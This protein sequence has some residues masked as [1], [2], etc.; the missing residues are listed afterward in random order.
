M[1]ALKIS[2]ISFLNTV[3]LMWDFEH[4]PSQEIRENFEIEYTVPSLCA[5][6]LLE[7]TADIGIIPVITMAEIRG[8][9]RCRIS[10]SPR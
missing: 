3:P 4:E 8:W 10:R 9:W 7:G 5:Q 1:R 2:A 6:A